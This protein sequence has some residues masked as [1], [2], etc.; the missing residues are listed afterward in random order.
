M[1]TVT[2]ILFAA[3]ILGFFFLFLTPGRWWPRRPPA[4]G[5]RESPTRPL[6]DDDTPAPPGSTISRN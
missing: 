2:F 1:Q 6:D 3:L 5:R 4:D